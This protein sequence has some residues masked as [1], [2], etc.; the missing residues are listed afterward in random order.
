[1]PQVVSAM[2]IGELMAIKLFW[3]LSQP[4]KHWRKYESNYKSE[5]SDGAEIPDRW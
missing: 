2:N 4:I 1:M 3:C 5:N